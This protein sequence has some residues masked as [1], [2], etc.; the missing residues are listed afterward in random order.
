[1]LSETETKRLIPVTRWNEYHAWPPPGGLRHLIFHAK[2]RKTRTGEMIQGNGLDMA[3]VRVGHRIL[4]DEAKFFE[5]A[6][7]QTGNPRRTNDL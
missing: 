3:L 4:I 6:R 7:A 2:P 5:W 1:M